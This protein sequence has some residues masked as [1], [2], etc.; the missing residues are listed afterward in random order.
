MAKSTLIPSL[1][2]REAGRI[3]R[4]MDKRHKGIKYAILKDSPR[5]QRA[6]EALKKAGL[7]GL[8]TREWIQKAN[9]CAVNTIAAELKANGIPVVCKAQGRSPDGANV[10]RYTLGAK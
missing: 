4:D 6:L 2:A 10:Y 1:Q 9:I 5:L 7:V 8:T 3:H